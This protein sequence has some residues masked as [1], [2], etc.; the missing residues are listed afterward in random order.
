[1][2]LPNVRASFGRPEAGTIIGMLAGSDTAARERLSDRIRDEGFDAV[3]DDPRTLNAVLTGGPDVRPSLI[4]YVMVR[5]AL[6]ETGIDDRTLADYLAALLSDFGREDRAFR[7]AA[8]D[9]D[10][11]EYLVDLLAAADTPDGR[12]QFLVRAHLGEYALWLSGIFPDYVTARVER[13]GA[14]GLR[15][16]EEMG[17]TGY[18][19]AAGSPMAS[20]HGVDHL[21]RTAAEVFGDL[22]V[23]L[24]RISDRYFFPGRGGSTERLLRQVT[25]AF[26]G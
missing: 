10:R 20:E 21:Y 1:M 2:I 25:D 19:M 8:G 13:R 18:R 16:F 15:Y 5:H 11:V 23:A 4:F 26:G 14:P 17:A 6:L 22:R 7:V 9:P 3:L 24:N 12:R